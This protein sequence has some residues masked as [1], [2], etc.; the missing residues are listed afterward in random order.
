ML[1]EKH[2]RRE[3]VLLEAIEPRLMLSA[4]YYVSP[5]GSD[6]NPGTAA[7]PFQTLQAGANAV[8]AD[9]NAGGGVAAGDTVI[10]RAGT[11]AAGMILGWNTSASGVANSPITFE[12]DPAAAPG[13]VIITGRDYETMDGIDVEQGSNYIVIQGFIINNTSG[14]ISH[15]GIR[16]AGANCVIQNNTANACGDWGIYTS[17]ADYVLI[18]D[19]V[20]SN[21]INQHGIYVANSTLDPVIQGNQIFGNHDG[22]LQLNGDASQGGDGLDTGA[23][24]QDNIIHDNGTG[25]GA[26]INCDGVQYARIQNNLLY[27]NHSTGIALFDEDGAAGSIDN[28]VVNNTIIEASDS[29]WCININSGST[30]N[31]VY[32]NILYNYNSNNGSIEISEDS[33]SGFVSN[34]NTV[35]G[36]FADYTTGL[37]MNQAQWMIFCGQDGNSF[38]ATPAQLFV[39]PAGGNYH[40]LA[41]ATAVDAGTSMAA[42]NQPPAYDLEGNPRPQGN[43]YDIGVYEFPSGASANSVLLDCGGGAIGSF[44]SD[45]DYSGGSV[46]SVT[47]TINTAQVANPAPQQVYQSQ[48]YG[49]FTYTVTGLTA[50][51]AY[52]VRMDFAEL[53]CTAVGQRL[54]NVSINGT[55]VLSNFDIYQSAGGSLKA[56]ARTIVATANSSGMITIAFSSI[57]GAGNP[58]VNG[59]EVNIVTPSSDTGPTVATAASAKLSSTSARLSVA[60]ADQYTGAGSLVY[61]WTAS[62][63]ASV[64]FSA[65]N[66]NAAKSSTASFKAA[67]QYTLTA[68]I[69]DTYGM[70]VTSSVV[71]NVPQTETQLS[72]TPFNPTVANSGTLQFTGTALDQFMNPMANQPSMTW[73]VLN[74][75]VGGTINSC[76]LYTAPTSG[77]G[78]DTVKV[79]DSKGYYA[80]V[81]VTVT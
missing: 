24:I 69:V 21:S 68:T 15:A 46:S 27:N 57:A 79:T 22:G 62:G 5:T 28:V 73:S 55:Q 12:A 17:F 54:F 3:R 6:S 13:S 75:G 63:P 37:V 25:G 26:A 78:T 45:T 18:Q 59:I 9:A 32:N 74:G 34:Y 30:G 65:N 40:L 23:L 48:R 67:G 61:I 35:D 20:A 58:V 7:A 4:T 52:D 2:N 81:V 43:G 80:T 39:N 53:Y 16:V 10:V 70:F 64:G 19:N 11:Y 56:I 41:G 8:T 50:N 38:I 1:R 49:N 71:V 44:G 51:T 66:S 60:G 47:S 72:L 76:G 36:Q 14:S 33:L 42:P 77:T 29:R 31:T